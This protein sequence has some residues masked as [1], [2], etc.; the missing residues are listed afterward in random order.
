M[1]VKK[2]LGQAYYLNQK[3]ISNK[4]RLE[5]LKEMANS[6]DIA[7]LSGIRVK[8]SRKA[9][10]TGDLVAKIVDFEAE[11][12]SKIRDCRDMLDTIE[13]QIDSLD[14]AKLKTLLM[15]RYMFFCTWGEI[16]VDMETLNN[17]KPYSEKQITRLHAQ[18]LEEF[19]KKFGNVLEC[20]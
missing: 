12:A 1:N 17:K 11:T 4:R 2:Y 16:A 6:A 15:K 5:E 3:I 10:K 13:K 8:T 19:E 7:E 20:L 18:A 9:D 14:D